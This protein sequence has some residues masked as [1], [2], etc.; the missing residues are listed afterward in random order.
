MARI[1]IDWLAKPLALAIAAAWLFIYWEKR[2][3]GRY[4]FQHHQTTADAEQEDF[5][6]D[7]RTGTVFGFGFAKDKS[8]AKVLTFYEIR[9]QERTFTGGPTKSK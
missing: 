2:D 5:V 8:G 3:N 1:L 9:P 6:F 7:T 4:V